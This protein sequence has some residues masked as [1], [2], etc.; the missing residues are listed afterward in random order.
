MSLANSHAQI[1]IPTLK[2]VKFTIKPTAADESSLPLDAERISVIKSAMATFS[3]PEPDWAKHMA[4]KGDL[5]VG[6]LLQKVAEKKSGKQQQS[7][8]FADF[9]RAELKGDTSQEKQ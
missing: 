3:V 6:R 8:N 7:E 5:D 1:T 4:A 9:E 2:N